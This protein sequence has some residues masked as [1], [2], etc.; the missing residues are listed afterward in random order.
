MRRQLGWWW[1]VGMVCA[2]SGGA[3]AQSPGEAT[4]YADALGPGWGV[5][6]STAPHTLAARAPVASG[7]RSISV[8]FGP[9]THLSFLHADLP[10]L[11]LDS[12]E[13]RV[14]GGTNTQPALTAHLTVS[15][16][17]RP[18]VQV[19][20]FCQGGAI[21]T[22]AWTLCRIPFSALG[23]ADAPLDGVVFTEGAGLT[24]SP[25][26]FD[27]LR[28]VAALPAAPTGLSATAS[29]TSVSL[30]WNSLPWV[31]G[32]NVYRATGPPSSSS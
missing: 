28:L 15:G 10:T 27:T 8:T 12:L 1:V 13:F 19:A 3:L 11:G 23:A 16:Q 17:A 4:L 9:G 5:E 25:M 6:G 32:Y 31:S 26:S 2:V 21:P 7:S 20:A 30:G 24:L 29:S 14:H 18:P 22:N